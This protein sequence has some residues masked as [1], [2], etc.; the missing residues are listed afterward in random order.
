MLDKSTSMCYVQY[1]DILDFKCVYF[2]FTLFLFSYKHPVVGAFLMQMRGVEMKKNI[3]CPNCGFLLTTADKKDNRVRKMRCLGCRKWIWFIPKS[4]YFEIRDIP[5][6]Q[7]SSGVR[8][9]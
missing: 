7:T 5:P 3:D 8:F 4:D 1:S 9:Y 2:I 6:R